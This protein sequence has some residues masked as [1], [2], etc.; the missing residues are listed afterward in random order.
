MSEK[1]TSP[2][3]VDQILFATEADLQAIDEQITAITD[4]IAEKQRTVDGFR[5][6]R[7]AIEIR[8]NGKPERKKPERS[9]G[10]A[11]A[12]NDAGGKRV[13]LIERVYALLMSEGS[14]PLPAIAE[15][16]GSTPGSVSGTIAGSD[17]FELRDGEVH[18]A[19]TKP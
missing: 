11:V 4:E 7:K 10:G 15:R 17:W 16:V 12:T 13:K 3:L 6:I 9:A 14:M 1:P 2:S 5:A 8:L 19:R 18:I